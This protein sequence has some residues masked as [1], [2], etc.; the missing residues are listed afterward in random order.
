M[1]IK[2]IIDKFFRKNKKV[3]WTIEMIEQKIGTKL[4][5]PN[6]KI[7]GNMDDEKYSE[8]KRFG[9][10]DIW[11]DEGTWLHRD[12]F[13]RRCN[14]CNFFPIVKKYNE[15]NKIPNN[16]ETDFIKAFSIFENK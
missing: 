5:Y 11:D 10:S 4:T 16:I 3:I 13:S 8:L 9:C 2:T 15:E 7:I 14:K 1:K 6:Q 12:C